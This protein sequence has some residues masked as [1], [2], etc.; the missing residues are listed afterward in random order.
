MR[1]ELDEGRRNAES[2]V[3]LA[4]AA[5]AAIAACFEGLILHNIALH[6]GTHGRRSTSYC[7]PRWAEAR[8]ETT[9]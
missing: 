4:V 3:P 5:A 7:G 1:T 9:A 8:G 6:D 2:N